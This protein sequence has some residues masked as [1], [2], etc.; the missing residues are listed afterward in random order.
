MISV[1]VMHQHRAPQLFHPDSQ[2]SRD[3]Y[4][5]FHCH[6]PR[7]FPDAQVSERVLDDPRRLFHEELYARIAHKEDAK[8]HAPGRQHIN[9]LVARMRLPLKAGICGCEGQ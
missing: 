4:S 3:F 7:S 9:P 5:S 2:R 8:Q 6:C 1:P